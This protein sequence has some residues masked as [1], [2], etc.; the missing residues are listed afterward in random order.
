MLVSSSTHVLLNGFLGKDI[1]HRRGLR[2]GDPLSS[3]LF[4]LVMDVMGYLVKKDEVKG[5]LQPTAPRTFH[6]HI[7]LY[8]ND[9]VIFRKLATREIV[10]VLNILHLFG[11]ASGLRK[12]CRKVKSFPLDTLNKIC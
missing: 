3:I 12:V 1:S 11:E 10:V 8:A 5:L 4:I 7:S 6:P 2:K 9:A